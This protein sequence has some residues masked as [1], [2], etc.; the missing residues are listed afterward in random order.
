MGDHSIEVVLSERMQ[1]Q[2][3]DTAEQTGSMETIGLE[4]VFYSLVQLTGCKISGMHAALQIILLQI[5]IQAVVQLALL[6]SG[7]LI[8]PDGGI[9]EGGHRGRQVVIHLEA[10]VH[11][12]FGAGVEVGGNGYG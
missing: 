2:F 4:H 5:S 12:D 1:G 8:C 3:A 7:Q 6:P 9:V 10:H 11:E